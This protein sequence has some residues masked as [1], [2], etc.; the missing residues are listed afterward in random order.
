MVAADVCDGEAARAATIA[1][2]LRDPA[3]DSCICTTPGAG[4]IRAVERVAG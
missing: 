4:A 2:L 1:R 3:V